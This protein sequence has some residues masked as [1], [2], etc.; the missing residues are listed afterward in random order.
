MADQLEREARG[1][2]SDLRRTAYEELA[3]QW[4][5][6]AD[7]YEHPSFVEE[8]VPAERSCPEMRTARRRLN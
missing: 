6:L 4:R 2:D 8:D 1:A 5:R 7:R 3:T